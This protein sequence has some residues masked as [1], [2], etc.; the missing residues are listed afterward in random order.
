M[1]EGCEAIYPARLHNTMHGEEAYEQAQ[2]DKSLYVAEVFGPTPH[3]L[4]S[5][6]S[7]FYDFY[8]IVWGCSVVDYIKL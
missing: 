1:Q 8:N 5:K 2:E 6:I 7:C 3:S 4:D